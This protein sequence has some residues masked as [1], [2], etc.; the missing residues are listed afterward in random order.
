MARWIFGAAGRLLGGRLLKGSS[1][2]GFT[3]SRLFGMKK[4]LGFVARQDSYF[5]AT[6][7][8]DI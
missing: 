8:A 1:G 2:A 4:L 7:L 5:K 3:K 6:A